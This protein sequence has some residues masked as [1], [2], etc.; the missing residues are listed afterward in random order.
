MTAGRAQVAVIGGGAAG[1]MAA[2]WAARA[3]ADVVL[4]ERNSDCGRKILI[5]GGG[6]CNVLPFRSRPRDFVSDS[7]RHLVRRLLEGWPL[8]AQR[9][10]FEDLLG[11][12]LRH[13]TDT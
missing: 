3:G 4:L 10:F 6:R 1:L 8:P 11:A 12:P 13:E 2:I 9:A 5:S 7:S